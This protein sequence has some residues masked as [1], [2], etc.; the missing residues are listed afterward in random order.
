MQELPKIIFGEAVD[1]CAE[2]LDEFSDVKNGLEDLE[3]NGMEY[4]EDEPFKKLKT[5]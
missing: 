1:E 2:L 4:I 5:F 3:E